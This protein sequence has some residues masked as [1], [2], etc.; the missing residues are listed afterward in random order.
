LRHEVILSLYTS[1]AGD[2]GGLRREPDLFA[3]DETPEKQSPSTDLALLDDEFTTDS[4]VNDPL[5][6][7][8]AV[9]RAHAINNGTNKVGDRSDMLPHF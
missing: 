2:D 9:Q 6:R 1:Q 3:P 7:S 8:Q 4:Q 5:S